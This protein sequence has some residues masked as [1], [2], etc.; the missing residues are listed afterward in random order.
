MQALEDVCANHL[1]TRLHIAQMQ[2]RAD[3]REIRQHPIAHEMDKCVDA[4]NATGIAAAK[5]CIRFACFN[6]LKHLRKFRRRVLQIRILDNDRIASDMRLRS[7][8]ACA[9][10]AVHFVMKYP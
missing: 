7:A 6:E 4:Q 1:V 3:I 5:Y 10:A 9:F 8:D 2:I